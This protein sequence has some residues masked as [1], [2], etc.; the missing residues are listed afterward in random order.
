MTISEINTQTVENLI[1]SY[2]MPRFD[3]DI[4]ETRYKIQI[5][6]FNKP[7]HSLIDTIHFERI[8]NN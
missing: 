1:N 7:D 2:L 5:N 8:I 4:F 6:I 3:L